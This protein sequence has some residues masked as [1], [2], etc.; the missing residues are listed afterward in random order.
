MSCGIRARSCAGSRA[1]RREAAR[2]PRGL[3]RP[4]RPAPPPPSAL[5]HP[6]ARRRRESGE[7]L[8]AVSQ[9]L[10]HAS[11]STTS[12]YLAKLEGSRDTGWQGSAAAPG[13]AR[14]PGGR[15]AGAGGRGGGARRRAGAALVTGVAADG[16][17][18]VRLMDHETDAGPSGWE[19]YD[20][21]L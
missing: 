19:I 20:V 16:R 5:G 3:R 9:H 7:T 15:G 14:W 10:G 4:R 1:R 12:R 13:G 17:W 18:V 6:S 8:E 21:L 11:L 2:R